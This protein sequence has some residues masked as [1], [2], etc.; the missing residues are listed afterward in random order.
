M[1]LQLPA[2]AVPRCST[3]AHVFLRNRRYERPIDADYRVLSPHRLLP[4]TSRRPVATP[5]PRLPASMALLA[6]AIA[7][8]VWAGPIDASAVKPIQPQVVMQA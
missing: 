8:A 7:L 5:K 1:L 2:N 6:I 3:T 4:A